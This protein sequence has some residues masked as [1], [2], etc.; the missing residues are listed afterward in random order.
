MVVYPSE[1]G[2][3]LFIYPLD[4]IFCKILR[5]LVVVSDLQL[6]STSVCQYD[7]DVYI[8]QLNDI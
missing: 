4:K 6:I 8:I 2:L 3:D 5:K 1:N 7:A